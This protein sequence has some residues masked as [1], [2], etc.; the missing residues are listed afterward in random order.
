MM[1]PA[2]TTNGSFVVPPS[3]GNI[4]DLAGILHD[5]NRPV[6]SIEEMEDSIQEGWEESGLNGSPTHR[7][8]SPE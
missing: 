3:T 4:M 7:A 5:P 8:D 2:N 6:T 1:S